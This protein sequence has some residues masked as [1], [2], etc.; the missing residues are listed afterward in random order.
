MA[1]PGDDGGD[2]GVGGATDDFAE[3]IRTGDVAIDLY[4]PVSLLG[5]W[6]ATDL[7]RAAYHLLT[8]GIAPTAIGALLFDLRFP[9]GPATWLAFLVSVLLAVVVSFGIRMLVTGTA[10]WLLDQTGIRTLAGVF[11]MFFSGLVVPLVIF[12][13]WTREVVLALPW[14]DR[15]AGIEPSR[16]RVALTRRIGVVFGQRTTLWW[17]LPLRDSSDLLRRI[18]RVDGADTE[19][20]SRSSAS[21]STS[22]TCSTSRCGSSRSVSGCVAMSR[23]HSCTTRRFSTSTS[24]PSASTSSARGGC[25]SSCAQSTPSATSPCC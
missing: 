13:G 18:Y 10:F 6:L 19:A 7:G 21:S 24:R 20:T 2:L 14:A 11:A 25:A 16:D 4:R 12:P 5:W 3:R 8:R 23:R 15:V 17:D 22:A 1:R 9:A